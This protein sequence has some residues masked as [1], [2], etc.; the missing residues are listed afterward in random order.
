MDK[1]WG[2]FIL[3]ACVLLSK[4]HWAMENP[5]NK[6][7]VYGK[8]PIENVNISGVRKI[9]SSFLKIPNQKSQATC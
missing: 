5:E 7:G 1:E 4:T 2:K 3:K 6:K 8:G 9:G